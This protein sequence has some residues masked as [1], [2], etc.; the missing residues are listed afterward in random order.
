MNKIILLTYQVLCDSHH[1]GTTSAL[2]SVDIRPYEVN[3][4][5]PKNEV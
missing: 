1:E 2:T 5:K 3:G 4:P